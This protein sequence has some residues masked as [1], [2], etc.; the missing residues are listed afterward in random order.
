MNSPLVS[1][2]MPCYNARE[3]LPW[4]L[5]SLLAQTFEDWELVL[6]DDG[7]T[8]NPYDIVEQASDSRIRY[9]R[10]PENRGRGYARQT[11]LNNCL[12]KY[13]SMLDADDWMYPTRLETQVNIL[14]Q[15]AILTLVSGGM[16]IVDSDNELV[17]LR[18]GGCG[19]IK[20]PHVGP[21]FPVPFAPSMF[22]RDHASVTGF[23][24]KLK[25]VEDVDFIIRMLQNRYY[26]TSP[27]SEYVYSEMKSVSAVKAAAGHK[28]LRAMM[29]QFVPAFPFQSLRIIGSSYLKSHVY[30]AAGILRLDD[31]VIRRRGRPASEA[32]RERFFRARSQLTA[33]VTSCFPQHS[34]LEEK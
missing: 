33:V 28:H 14:E 20:G 7:S 30:R 34:V 18:S 6:V 5:A 25:T 4:A 8:D 26:C 3:S 15:E 22:R 17:G 10:L 13:I 27:D 31:A 9:I 29:L 16:V 24:P 21:T 1:V 12:G 32:E 19:S 2:M 23:N 11:A